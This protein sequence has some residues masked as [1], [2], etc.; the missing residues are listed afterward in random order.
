MINPTINI[1]YNR[2]LDPIFVGWI[3]AQPKYKD[4]KIPSIKIVLQKVQIFKDTWA[5]VGDTIF[6]GMNEATGLSFKRNHFDVHVVSGNPREFSFPIVV[7]SRHTENEFIQSITHELIHCLFKD[8]RIS[9]D[10]NDPYPHNPHILVCA[11]LKFVYLD[12]LE[13]PQ[14]LEENIRNSSGPDNTEYKE[15][16]DFV[17]QNDYR[18][19]IKN[20]SNGL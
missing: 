15:A 3:C 4:W 18:D 16:W 13:N 8:N 5:K 2:F 7:R 14:L 12:A 17:E 10:G 20:L 1:E 11:V 9:E 19:I 6:R